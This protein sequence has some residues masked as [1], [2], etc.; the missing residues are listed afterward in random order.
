MAESLPTCLYSAALSPKYSLAPDDIKY[1]G[2]FESFNMFLASTQLLGSSKI[3][4]TVS[5]IRAMQDEEM[6]NIII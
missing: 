4:F 6:M 2:R 3:L 5:V 1:Q